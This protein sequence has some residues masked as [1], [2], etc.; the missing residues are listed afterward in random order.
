MKEYVGNMKKYVENMKKYEGICRYTGFR[1]AHIGSGT[2]KNSE[3]HVVWALGL[4]KI[5]TP[6]F[7]GSGTWKNY[8]LHPRPW[9]SRRNFE[10]SANTKMS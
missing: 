3:L 10:T 6:P 8:E 4:V 5:P 9:D 7:I 1:T 2:S